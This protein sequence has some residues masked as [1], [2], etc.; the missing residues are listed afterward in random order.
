M[1]MFLASVEGL[2]WEQD[3]CFKNFECRSLAAGVR[4]RADAAYLG[5]HGPAPAP[6]CDGCGGGWWRWR[7][8]PSLLVGDSAA[9][10]AAAAARARAS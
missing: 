6:G 4:G 7:P 2:D 9:A 3:L 8:Q 5:P 1:L 10:A